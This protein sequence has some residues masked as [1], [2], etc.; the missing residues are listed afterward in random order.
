[1]TQIY[2]LYFSDDNTDNSNNNNNNNNNN[3][4]NKNFTSFIK[5]EE[6]CSVDRLLWF[7]QST[8]SS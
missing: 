1:M 4:S 8:S 7:I 6:T 5:E 2:L 3:I